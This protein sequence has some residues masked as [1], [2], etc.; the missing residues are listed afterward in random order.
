[1]KQYK[2]DLKILQRELVQLQQWVI[3]ENKKVVI[4]FEGR[5]SSGKGGT[6]NRLIQKLN[7]NHYR[8]VAKGK[9]TTKENKEKYFTRWRRELPSKGEIVFLDRSW[10]TRAGV[11][12]VMAFASS[13][14]VNKFYKDVKKFEKKLNDNGVIL[15][16]YWLSISQST[17]EKRFKLRLGDDTK[18]WKLSPMDLASRTKWDEYTLAKER[19]FKETNFKFSPWIIVNGNNK[20]ECRLSVIESILELI[21]YS[22]KWI[23]PSSLSAIHIA[24]PNIQPTNITKIGFN[25]VTHI[26][27]TS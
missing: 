17:Q 16:K 24:P 3:R 4:L 25:N 15:L 1:M 13:E 9:P 20:R 14:Q 21:P 2:K 11:E 12:S 5:D 19:M 6:I 18:R 10:Y 26:T 23:P 27:N 7:P 22:F 8:V